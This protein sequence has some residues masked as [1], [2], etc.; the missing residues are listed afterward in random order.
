MGFSQGWI[1]TLARLFS[2]VNEI[3]VRSNALRHVLPDSRE[4]LELV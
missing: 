1:L 2:R 3:Y 4:S